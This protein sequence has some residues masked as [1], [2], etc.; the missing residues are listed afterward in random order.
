MIDLNG[1]SYNTRLIFLT[2][3]TFVNDYFLFTYCQL[4]NVISYSS[5]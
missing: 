3:M 4:N 2:R 1:T 5:G